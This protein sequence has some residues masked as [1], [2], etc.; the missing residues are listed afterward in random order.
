M[1]MQA[2]QTRYAGYLFRSRMEARWAVAFDAMKVK[3]EYEPEGFKL[4]S[5]IYYLPD[6]RVKLAADRTLWIE[7]K[8]FGVDSKE[9]D[10]FMQFIQDGS[11]G[12]ILHDIPDPRKLIT[13]SPWYYTNDEPYGWMSLRKGDEW[14]AKD[15][16]GN[17]H[18]QSCF[19]DNYYLFCG[20]DS[21]NKIGFEFIGHGERMGC[22]CQSNN[23]TDDHP[24]IVK[25][26]AAA[27]SARFE[28]DQRER[29][30]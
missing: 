26:F 21:C 3:W 5:G 30:D 8:P 18:K 29:W 15:V 6:F 28:H 25:A 10:E 4:P 17:E 20:C 2:I 27:R 24:L 23:C 13:S 12:T 7:V 1:S 14:I 11:T 9:F 16:D 19:Q 22:D